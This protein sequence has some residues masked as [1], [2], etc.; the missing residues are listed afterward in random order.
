MMKKLKDPVVRRSLSSY[1]EQGASLL[2]K[3]FIQP[4]SENED[5]ARREYILNVL[6]GWAMGISF[7]ALLT[8]SH[9]LLVAM[10]EGRAF[11]GFP[12]LG[13]FIILSIFTSLLFLS[14]KGFIR[15]SAIV[16]TLLYLIPVLYASIEWGV[17]LPQ[18]IAIYALLIV[19]TSV[20]INTRTSIFF[21]FFLTVFLLTVSY[22][23]NESILTPASYW[24]AQHFTYSDAI[25]MVATFIVIAA[26]SSLSNREIEKSLRRVRTSERALKEE[27]DLLEVKVEERTKE[28]RE[29]QLAQISQLNR[30][31]EFGRIASG[32][33]HD[34]SSPLTALSLN[35]HMIKGEDDKRISKEADTYLQNALKTT[36]R[37]EDYFKTIRRQLQTQDERVNF[38]LC[39]EFEKVMDVLSYKARKGGVLVEID[40]KKIRLT[41]S[42]VKFDQVIANLLSNAI[43]AC[44]MR[45]EKGEGKV[46]VRAIERHEYVVIEVSD[47]GVGI[48]KELQ[49]NIFQPFFTTKSIEQ[50]T[51]IG[52][53]TCKNIMEKDFGGTITFDSELGKGTTF[54][55]KFP[56]YVRHSEEAREHV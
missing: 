51:G 42:V 41:A 35:L 50:G 26:V 21:T 22:L 7:V 12:P 34:L 17:D 24:R 11:E 19:M 49:S 46:V 56:T 1:V 29:S 8:T 53:S 44:I 28:L 43:D 55:A 16:L 33:F 5:I 36:V 9:G 38:D 37:L 52:L 2:F 45:K 10:A 40:C 39:E 48:P 15:L 23:H 32:L 3:Y 25:A 13:I 6:L 31:V 14:R 54:T 4:K 20:L 18:G 27:R 47:N 30:F